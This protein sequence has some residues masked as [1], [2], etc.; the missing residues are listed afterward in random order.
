MTLIW[1]VLGLAAWTLGFLFLMVLMRMASAEDRAALQQEKLLE[2]LLNASV[3]RAG[4]G[5]FGCIE[6]GAELV[7]DAADEWVTWREEWRR[8]A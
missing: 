4:V 3:T 8:A 5:Q 2:R 6:R 1:I 7:V